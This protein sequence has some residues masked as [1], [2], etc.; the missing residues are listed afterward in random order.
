MNDSIEMNTFSQN[1]SMITQDNKPYNLAST[2]NE[3][4][5]IFKKIRKKNKDSS[6]KKIS[7]S[8]SSNAND[9]LKNIII[10]KEKDK[11]PSIAFLELKEI[12]IIGINLISFILFYFCF[13]PLTHYFSLVSIFIFPMDLLSFILCAISGI[14]TSGVITL[15]ILKKVNIYHMLYMS[16]YFLFVFFLH[17]YKYIAK[18][19]YDQSISVF[20]V[21]NSLLVNFLCCFFIFFIILKY[22]YYERCIKKD[23]VFIKSF[24]SRWHSYE[25]IKKSESE[26]S[27]LLKDKNDNY[28][29]SNKKINRIKF[30]LIILCLISIQISYFIFIGYKK[31]K[32]FNCNNWDIGINGTHINNKIDNCII[33]K[34]SEYCYMDYFKGYFDLTPKDNQNCSLREPTQEKK[35]FLKNIE[36][37]NNNVDLFNTKVFAFPHTNLVKK[38]SLKNQ[39]SVNDFGRLV[40]ADIYNLETNKDK[41]PKPE[42]ILDFSENN[43]YKGK[44]AELK[45]NLVFNESLSKQRKK[46]ENNNSLYDNIFMLYLDATSRAHFQRSFPKL[47]NFIKNFMSYES[48]FSQK[49]IDAYQ[50]MKYHSFGP[51]TPDNI[52]PMFY[53][54][55]KKSNAGTNHIR[56]FKQIGFITGHE[57]DMCNKEQYDIFSDKN[58]KREYEEWDHENIAYLCDGNYFE[59]QKPYPGDRGAFSN[60]ERCLYGHKVSFYMINY[61]K[62][63]WEKYENNKKYFRMAFNYGH[64][65]TGAVISYLDEPL[66]DFFFE[67]YEKGYFNNTAVFIVSDHGNQ[68]N[69]I[70][71]V[72]CP[73]QFSLEQ[74][75]GNFILLLSRNKFSNIYKENLINNQNTLVT[76]YDIH[77][78]M[79]H[80]VFGNNNITSNNTNIMYSVNNKGKSVFLKID[81]YERICEKYDEWISDKFCGCFRVPFLLK[82][83]NLTK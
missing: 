45:I 62:Q 60:K 64:E 29:A 39:I 33:L 73:T 41:D 59:I 9:E 6:N 66:Y 54:N 71:D 48:D 47:Q 61:A 27:L 78:T 12:I 52:L 14:I 22:L 49:K 67:F 46:L 83:K 55:S 34:P 20:Y 44:Y 10:N 17:H 25:I 23:N 30:F 58:D 26:S 79:I 42:A 31:K 65:K 77:D 43:V 75:M 53:G 50:F 36:N 21:F 38:Y 19:N 82:N 4:Q 13:Y 16:F 69:G 2:S 74:K 35:N 72:I 32:A 56:Y 24:E 80:I 8:Y 11:K 1:N 3:V 5:E 28:V 63:F 51:I 40:N 68:N 18:S 37:N 7:K 81:E 15:I 70:Y 57:V 76:P